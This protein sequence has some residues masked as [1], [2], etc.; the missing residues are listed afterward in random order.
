MTSVCGKLSGKRSMPEAPLKREP[1]ILD[2]SSVHAKCPPDKAY[3]HPCCKGILVIRVRSVWAE[4]IRNAPDGG[5]VHEQ[6]FGKEVVRGSSGNRQARSQG[7]PG[8]LS[9]PG[10][11]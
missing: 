11:H 3:S 5:A 4:P 2:V 8:H 9:H 6:L 1:P 10:R 7:R